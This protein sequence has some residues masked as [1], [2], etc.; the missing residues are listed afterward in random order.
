MPRLDICNMGSRSFDE[1]AEASQPT[2]FCWHFQ[3]DV[4]YSTAIGGGHDNFKAE[5]LF[6]PKGDRSFIARPIPTGC[7]ADESEFGSPQLRQSYVN[8]RKYNRSNSGFILPMT[9][10]SVDGK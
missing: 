6:A 4:F 7:G 9:F 3:S 10:M 5:K 1:R 8:D 2:T